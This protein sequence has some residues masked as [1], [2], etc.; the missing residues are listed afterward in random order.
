MNQSLRRIAEKKVG[1]NVP[2]ICC[3]LGGLTVVKLLWL[4]H[5]S[6]GIQS[7]VTILTSKAPGPYH[8]CTNKCDSLVNR[9]DMDLCKG[10]NTIPNG[11]VGDWV[12]LSMEKTTVSSR[13]SLQ[14]H[15]AAKSMFLACHC[16]VVLDGYAARTRIRYPRFH[17][18][19]LQCM[20][21][22][23]DR[24]YRTA[25]VRLQYFCLPVSYK[26]GC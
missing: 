16:A 20:A 23:S 6:S 3:T 8:T 1:R 15:A 4:F 11:V 12:L 7:W 14:F 5:T 22:Y 9:G 2:I 19:Q 13:P 24:H 21:S 25:I 26:F 18:V 10:R 17:R